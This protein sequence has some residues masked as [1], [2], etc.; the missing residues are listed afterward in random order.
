MKLSRLLAVLSVFVLLAVCVQADTWYVY[1]P[2]G[3]TLNLRSPLNNAVIGSIPYGTRLETDNQLSTS[4]AA[5]VTWGGL[6]GFVKWSFLVK[7]PPPARNAGKASAAPAVTAVPVAGNLLPTDGEGA[8]MIQALGAYIEYTS[9]KQRTGKFSA[10]SFNAPV[11]VK[12]TADVPKNK[13]IDYWVID[14][15]RYDFLPWVPTSFTLD[16]VTG[17]MIVEAVLKN[18]SSQTLLS[19]EAIRQ[20]RTGETL[21][22]KTIHARLCHVKSDLKGAGG[23]LSSFDFTND[24]QNRATKKQETGG[25]VTVRVKATIPSGKK[26][27]YWKF[28]DVKI[29]FNKNVTEMIVHTLNVSKTY[30]PVFGATEKT[31]ERENPP[32]DDPVYYKVTCR[33]CTFSGGGYSGASSGTVP[34]GT[35]ITVTSKYSSSDISH[36]R[37]NGSVLTKRITP[38]NGGDRVTVDIRTST[39]TLTINKDTVVECFCVVN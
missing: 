2:N 18:Q 15:T 38:K 37:V 19:A 25:Q 6:S 20:S 23:W 4:T 39:V 10:V 21:L 28:D 11:K 31:T 3:K 26:I 13:T 22:V 27:S 34:A 29:D 36:W 33:N 16:N 9:S 5:Y 35:R 24:Y 7:D 17:S 8:A 1:T 32:Q 14:G 12:V 30:E